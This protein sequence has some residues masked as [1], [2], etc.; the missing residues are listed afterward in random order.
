MFAVP[1]WSVS[2]ER[3]KAEEDAPLH[4]KS[5]G[6]AAK[7]AKKPKA[8]KRKENMITANNVADY[9]EQVIEGKTQ[10]D[11][12]TTIQRDFKRQKIQGL[13][14][15]AENEVRDH[16]LEKRKPKTSLREEEVQA[17][18]KHGPW[19]ESGHVQPQAS[20]KRNGKEKAEKWSKINDDV[21]TATTITEGIKEAAP[22]LKSKV[23]LTPLQAK[24]RDKLVSSRFRY[25][26]E[27]LYTRPSA[28]ALAVF[29]ESPDIFSEYHEGFRRQVAVWPENPVDGYIALLRAR[30]NIRASKHSFQRAGSQGVYPSV[31]SQ[32]LP[33]TDGRTVLADLGCGDAKIAATL[34][35]DKK[36]LRLDFQSFDLASVT[37]LVTKADIASL[38]LPDNS[39]DLAIFCLAL[40]GTNWL[41]F[42]EEAWRVVRRGGE[43]WVAEIKS[44][45]G[46][47]TTKKAPSRV[48]DH[49]MSRQ[50][51][52]NATLIKKALR[53]QEEAEAREEEAQLAVEVDGVEVAGKGGT[54][55][56]AFV[57]SLRKRGFLLMR[58]N[59][60]VQMENKMFVKM[61]FVKAGEPKRGKH[62]NPGPSMDA[63]S[64]K[65]RK[66]TEDPNEHVNEAE[67]KILK[68]C[69]YKI[70]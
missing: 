53:A 36:K 66:F 24:M 68:P 22:I 70:R 37:P 35:K 8:N 29:S 28:E 59:D 60:A 62:A 15:A 38:P 51:R 69:V 9:W 25:L 3:L 47:V 5:S 19:M 31:A 58:A 49:N 1:G 46:A 23:K 61:F 33:F 6:D 43:L 16:G 41:E 57:E 26:N 27:T 13:S 65:R 7:K 10:E 50:G 44:R 40:M 63:G 67:K 30:A 55:V 56:T 14:H 11:A 34:G 64:K 39:V 42:I 21:E 2:A 20:Q 18:S 4:S 54:D 12:E 17:C 32:R 48:A 52:K 45:F